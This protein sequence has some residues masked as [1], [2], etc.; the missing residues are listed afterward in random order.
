MMRRNFIFSTGGL[1]LKSKFKI[2]IPT[3][4]AVILI[5]VIIILN[6]PFNLNNALRFN[7]SEQI[8]ISISTMKNVGGRAEAGTEIFNFEKGSAE[9]MAVNEL[10]EAYSYNLTTAKDI[11]RHISGNMT[12][13][14]ILGDNT[15]LFLINS[16]GSNI[17]V[18]GAN[19]RMKQNK[20][21]ELID[22]ILNI[23]GIQ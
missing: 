23:C 7:E 1:I 10:L 8:V 12:T 2:I 18:N 17:T 15:G 13:I 4:V 9:F 20:I 21:E 14:T 22:K 5:A 6:I 19:Y 11:N 16:T 3:S